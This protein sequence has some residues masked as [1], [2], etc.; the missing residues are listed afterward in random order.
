MTCRRAY[1]V[2]ATNFTNVRV[3]FPGWWLVSIN[4]DTANSNAVIV[5][6]AIEYGG[7]L[8]PV[9]FDGSRTHTINPGEH[10]ESDTIAGLALASGATFYMRTYVE[11]TS[12]AHK[13]PASLVYGD[14]YTLDA[15]VVDATG[16]LVSASADSPLW[17]PTTI[18]GTPAG[19]Y[20]QAVIIGDSIV[21]DS[22]SWVRQGLAGVAGL[23]VFACGAEKAAHFVQESHRRYRGR[24]AVSFG[25]WFECYGTNDTNVGGPVPG[26]LLETTNANRCT[27]W[28]YARLHGALTVFANT[29][30]PFTASTD[31]WAT[32]AN[33]S[34]LLPDSEP[35]RL[36]HNTWL[37]DGAPLSATTGLPVAT[38]TGGAL[39]TVVIT[40]NGSTHVT[41]GTRSA[42]HPL[43]AIFDTG[44]IVTQTDGG[45]EKWVP[46]WTPDGVHPHGAGRDAQALV[47][48]ADLLV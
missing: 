19:T 43:N 7:L 23:Q 21:T 4:G 14:T 22:Q 12:A 2:A 37:R 18:M 20:K 9:T 24:I 17:M 27:L 40:W 16:A 3:S 41:T 33:Q 34:I 30:A 46:T 31:N 15:D 42:A 32:L 1:K 39:R 5:K 44:V 10:V 48:K 29:I 28:R 35:V 8:Y 13:Y 11:L 47:F 6:A 25:N 26:G 36:N 45:V 38:G